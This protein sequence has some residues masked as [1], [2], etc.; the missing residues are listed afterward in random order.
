MP[1]CSSARLVLVLALLRWSG[2]DQRLRRLFSETRQLRCLSKNALSGCRRVHCKQGGAS[3][4]GY[5]RNAETY[6]KTPVVPTPGFQTSR[7]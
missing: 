5:Q 6:Q 4:L 7:Q 3:G 2:S 1:D